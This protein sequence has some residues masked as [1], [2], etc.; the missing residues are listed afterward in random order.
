MKHRSAPT[1]HVLVK[2]AR[3][4]ILKLG[5]SGR[6]DEVVP[7]LDFSGGEI[8]FAFWGFLVAVGFVGLLKPYLGDECWV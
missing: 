7:L 5:F 3:Q 4:T 8:Q 2:L 6:W 1:R